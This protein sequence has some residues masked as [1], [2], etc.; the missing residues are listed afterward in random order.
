MNGRDV[1]RADEDGCDRRAIAHG[2]K[3]AV[4]PGRRLLSV[5]ASVRREEGVLVL[6]IA[7]PYKSAISR[8]TDMTVL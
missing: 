7:A 8:I 6:L 1:R 3:I 5:I 2:K 4:T